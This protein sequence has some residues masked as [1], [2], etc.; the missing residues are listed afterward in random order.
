MMIDQ[1]KTLSSSLATSLL[2]WYDHMGRDLPWRV[3]GMPHPTPYHVWLSEI[4]LQQT[5][6]AT[7]KSYFENFITRWPTLENFAAAPLD[8]ILH[9]WQGLG[10]YARARNMVKCA[11]VL[12]QDYRGQFPKT[13]LELEKLPG[14]GPYTAAAV[15]AIAFED[16]VTPVDGNVI[17][18]LSRVF[19]IE[20]PLP[21][22][23][24]IIFEKAKN[25][26]PPQ[27]T[28]DFA[29][30]LMDLGATICTP[31]SPRCMLCPWQKYCQGF[32][33][34]IAETLPQKAPKTLKPW[35]HAV[36][37]ILHNDQEEIFFRRR[38]EKGLLGGM[39]EVPSTLWRSDPW[40]IFDAQTLSP[41]E[42]HWDPEIRTAQHSF[43]HFHFDIKILHGKLKNS[44]AVTEH[45]E[46]QSRWVKPEDFTKLALPTVI[47][48]ILKA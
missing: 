46:D 7:V 44:L 27:R 31:R 28:G 34:G 20:T 10:Y 1:N 24:P 45:V 38:P 5:T 19:A 41:F 15:A 8:D 35:R 37:Y 21:Q 25:L 33:Q 48:K 3:K 26:T 36:A 42:C 23:L 22:S 4:M 39:M 40:E 17:R 14:I 2:E 43:T 18:V 32:Q 11:H 12:V 16:A 30:A 13:A 9:A 47:K 29:Q 6:V